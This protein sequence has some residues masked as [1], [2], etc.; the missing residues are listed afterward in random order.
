MN[1]ILLFGRFS[2]SR[3]VVVVLV[4]VT[5]FTLTMQIARGASTQYFQGSTEF[6]H[7]KSSGYVNTNGG[8]TEL[9]CFICRANIQTRI[10]PYE[11]IHASANLWVEMYHGWQ[12][13]VRSQCWWDQ[14]YYIEG[15]AEMYCW[16]YH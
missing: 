5:L 2:L 3:R 10:N 9:G 15:S 6:G 7:V 11:T 4:M 16:Y 12:Y 13:N 8:R 1:K 14:D